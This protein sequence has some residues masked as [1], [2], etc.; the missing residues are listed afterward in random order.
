ME[1]KEYIFMAI[2]GILILSFV[3]VL[4][5]PVSASVDYCDQSQLT[6]CVN[7]YELLP[8]E[9]IIA[10]TQIAGYID[11]H[12]FIEENRVWFKFDANKINLTFDEIQ[13]YLDNIELNLKVNR[14]RTTI[15]PDNQ[16]A[17]MCMLDLDGSLNGLY[18]VNGELLLVSDD[19]RC[20][21]LCAKGPCPP[22]INLN[23]PTNQR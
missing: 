19:P 18:S 5:Y 21:G 16:P 8:D 23:Q 2:I 1:K 17:P 12:V 11:H 7:I 20:F 3:F 10:M 13:D 22:A 14:A 15:Y 6:I 9:Q 4:P